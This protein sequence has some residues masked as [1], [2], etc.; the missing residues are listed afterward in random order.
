MPPNPPTSAR[1][2]ARA[3]GASPPPSFP[4]TQIFPPL[5]KILNTALPAHLE[6]DVG[7]EQLVVG[8]VDDGGV[9]G[10]RKHMPAS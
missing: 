5:H 4:K 9:V 3:G 7:E 6:V 1:A 10:T 2:N 8:G